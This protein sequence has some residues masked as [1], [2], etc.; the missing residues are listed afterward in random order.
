[1]CAHRENKEI[2]KHSLV[3]NINLKDYQRVIN[4]I[5]GYF[6]NIWKDPNITF[7]HLIWD[8]NWLNSAFPNIFINYLKKG[9]LYKMSLL[10]DSHFEQ[11]KKYSDTYKIKIKPVSEHYKATIKFL[12]EKYGET[13]K[14]IS[15]DELYDLA[16]EQNDK[17]AEIAYYMTYDDVKR[18]QH[19]LDEFKKS[20]K[21]EISKLSKINI[22]NAKKFWKEE[23]VK[24][25]IDIF[26]WSDNLVYKSLYETVFYYLWWEKTREQNWL[27]LWFDR[28]HDLFQTE[29]FAYGYKPDIMKSM[30]PLLYA[31][32]TGKKSINKI[33]ELS[34]RQF[35]HF[36][37]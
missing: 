32:R 28:D 19:S 37:E 34:F 23:V 10:L 29:A 30:V 22:E 12:K 1:M 33:N 18:I 13:V 8:E 26:L 11:I 31:R 21:D 9:E 17:I 15:Y 16:E 3:E 7:Y 35:W 27:A 36:Y 20:N 5:Y 24:K 14:N 25:A 2:K 4:L 6:K